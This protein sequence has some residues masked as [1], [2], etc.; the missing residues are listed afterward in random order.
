MGEAMSDSTD[1]TAGRELEPGQL[2]ADRYLIERLLGEGDRKRTY[3]AQDTK[4][5][6]RLIALAVVKPE[7]RIQDPDG[8][9]REMEVLALIGSNDNVVSI[10]DYDIEGQTHYLV[11]EYL[12]GG[13]LADFIAKR[14]ERGEELSVEEIL[15]FGRQLCRGLS[16]L[17]RRGVIHRDI[18][19]GNIWLDE[20]HEAHLGDFDSAIPVDAMHDGRPLTTDAYASPEEREGGRLDGRSDLFSLGG[21]LTCLAAGS[22]RPVEASEVRRLRP[23]LPSSLHDLITSLVAVRPDDRPA[24]AASV[25]AALEHIRRGSDIPAVIAGGEGPKVEFKAS[26]RYPHDLPPQLDDTARAAAVK[27]KIPELQKAVLKTIAA[28]LNSHGG[29]LLVGVSDK[30]T[31]VGIEADFAT[32]KRGEQDADSWQLCLKQAVMNA[33]GPDVWASLSLALERTNNGTVARLECPRRAT[34]T[35]LTDGKEEEFYIRAASSTERLPPA[36]AVHYIR[37]RWPIGAGQ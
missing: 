8:T 5:R 35:W 10:Y 26:F 19:P 13:T 11:F 6:D 22:Q 15:K 27:Q 21:I 37:A 36:K 17:H 31:V 14:T 2:F 32:F 7:A 9:V 20:R 29:T 1:S 34:E 30:G 23:D 18:S 28:F 16:H 4:M 25:L 3:L 24:D 12:S 33:F